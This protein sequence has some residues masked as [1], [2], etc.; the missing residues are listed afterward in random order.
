LNGLDHRLMVQV[1]R[2]QRLVPAGVNNDCRRAATALHARLPVLASRP[3]WESTLAHEIQRDLTLS[4]PVPIIAG[5]LLTI[6][7]VLQLINQLLEQTQQEQALQKSLLTLKD[8]LQQAASEPLSEV[9][10][11]PD[12]AFVPRRR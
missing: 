7:A 8:Q 4:F 6:A 10:R 3:G 12:E 2:L 5:V 9:E 11:T 1:H